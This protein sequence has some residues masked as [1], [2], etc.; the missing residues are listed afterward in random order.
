[1]NLL[2]DEQ[3]DTHDG[4]VSIAL[5]AFTARTGLTIRSLR[6]V[7]RGMKDDEVVQY[8]KDEGFNAVV[9]FNHRDFGKKKALYRDLMAAGVSVVVLRPPKNPGFTPERQVSLISQ[10]LQCIERHL[11]GVQLLGPILIRLSPTECRHRTLDE[12]EA[13]F[14]KDSRRLP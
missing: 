13:E 7:K 5:N 14:T 6:T 12:I 9:S 4:S 2:L 1:V 11:T 10:H 8:C 3:L